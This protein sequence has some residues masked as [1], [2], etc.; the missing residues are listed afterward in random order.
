VGSCSDSSADIIVVVRGGSRGSAPYG[1]VVHSTTLLVLT[2]LHHLPAR[3]GIHR[4][5]VPVA[6]LLVCGS[7]EI[8]TL[9]SLRPGLIGP[10]C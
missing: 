4:Y 1:V 5:G 8:P 2:D 6:S 3:V 10:I 7:L 9:R